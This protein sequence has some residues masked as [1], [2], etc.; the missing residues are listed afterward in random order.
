MQLFIAQAFRW[1]LSASDFASSDARGET[2]AQALRADPS[3]F[4]LVVVPASHV[5]RMVVGAAWIPHGRR[6]G[7][8]QDEVRVVLNQFAHVHGLVAKLTRCYGEAGIG[9]DE[10][11]SGD[12][13]LNP[14]NSEAYR[15]A[16]RDVMRFWGDDQVRW[17]SLLQ[18]I[19]ANLSSSSSAAASRVYSSEGGE[20]TP[21]PLRVRTYYRTSLPACDSFCTSPR[22]APRHPINASTLLMTAMSH[23]ADAKAN[24]YSHS[25]VFALNDVSRTAFRARG[26]GVIDAEVM[27]GMRVDAYPASYDGQGDKL[28]FC[29]P[30]PPDW[31][32]DVVV[33]R[34]ARDRRA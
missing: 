13:R 11:T 9:Q 14:Y 22:G 25:L 24:D 20:G 34:I 32:L 19:Q 3:S 15:L 27:M 17:A 16:A 10:S 18:E 29:Q 5:L 2:C 1:I 33:R 30:G 23:T 4:G 21:R 8:R 12:Y 31:A 28:H 6:R 26:H 7:T